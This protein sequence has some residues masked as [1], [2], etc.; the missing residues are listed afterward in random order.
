MTTKEKI[1]RS[2]GLT[3][4]FIRQIVENPKMI[5]KIP[6]KSIIEFVEKDFPVTLS[7][8]DKLNGKRKLIKV[9]SHMEV[10]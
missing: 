7:A 8:S 10:I 1:N 9:K 6:D 3:F 4:D 5:S 2:I